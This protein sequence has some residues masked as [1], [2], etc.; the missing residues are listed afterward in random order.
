MNELIIIGSGPA[1]L[2]AAIY[3]SRGELKPLLFAGSKSGGQLMTTT[4]VENFPGFPDGVMGPKLM[5]DMI[6]QAK[7]FGT[8]ILNEDITRV[9][10]TGEIKKVYV[11][12]KEFS[13]KS[14][15]LATG[16][17][18]RTLGID[19][20]NKFWGKGVSTCATCDGPFY[21]EK[22]V[23]VIGGGDSAA[24]ESSFLTKFA[25]KVYVIVRKD[26]LKAS[27]IMAERVLNNSKIEI[28]Y[29]TEVK[30]VLGNENVTGLK[31]LNSQTNVESE[32]RVDGMFLAI[33]H[34]PNT[35]FLQG[36]VEIDEL[37]F[38]KVKEGSH[39]YTNIDGVFVAGD[40]FDHRYR[41]AITAAGMGC[42]ASIDAERWLNNS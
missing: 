6:A 27:K 18:S 39:T 35:K 10:F 25:S 14:V 28:I 1:G 33:G 5:I 15:I 19:S 29:H 32:L 22:I 13:A 37:G 8:E 23:A 16:A 40:V 12:D 3:A 38:V 26:V 2:T 7:V 4:K 9:D 31:I 21:R 20:E 11:G 36:Q 42:M 30:E 17:S 34:I 24:E 41:Q